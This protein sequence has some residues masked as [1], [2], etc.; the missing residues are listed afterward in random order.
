VD[1]IDEIIRNA[2]NKGEFLNL[3]GQGKPLRHDDD[4]HTPPHLRMAHK[5]L[6]D[7]DLAPDWIAQGQDLDQKHEALLKVL[8]RAAR[9]YRGAVND[10]VRSSQPEQNRQH[11]RH[12]WESA[13]TTLRAEAAQHNRAVLSYNLKVPKGVTHKSTF[14]VDREAAKLVI[15]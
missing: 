1:L 3:P 9:A 12:H 11:A 10:A 6:K 5:L 15:P 2:Q 14:D 13:K 7:N 8:Q 4:P